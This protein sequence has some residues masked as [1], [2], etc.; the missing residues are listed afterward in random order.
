MIRA[1]QEARLGAALIKTG[2]DMSR[3]IL[4]IRA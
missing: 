2:E 3:T 4:D 1:G